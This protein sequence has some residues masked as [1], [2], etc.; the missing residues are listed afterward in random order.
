[1]EKYLT[2][3]EA[4]RHLGVTQSRVRQYILELRLKSEKIGRDHLIRE[5][6]LAEFA[7]CGKLKR[8]RPKK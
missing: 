1:M 6:D 8:G 4:A 7:E 3:E 2:T 5:A